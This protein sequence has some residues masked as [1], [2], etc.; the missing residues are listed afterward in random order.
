[1]NIRQLVLQG[2]SAH[3]ELKRSTGQRTEAAKTACAM[4]NGDGGVIIFGVTDKGEICGQQVSSKTIEDVLFEI[5]RIDPPVFPHVEKIP[6]KEDLHLILVTIAKGEDVYTYDGRP[7]LRQGPTTIIMPREEYEQ[8]VIEKMHPYKRWEKE[9]VPSGISIS[10]LD[11]EEMLL[12]LQN[13]VALGRMTSPKKDDVRSILTGLGLIVEGRLINA[14]VVLYGKS[15][16]LEALYPQF[17]LRIARFRGINRLGD[18][19]DN[20]Q[21]WGHAFYLMRRAESFLL[22]HMQIAGRVVSGKLKREDYPA[23]APRAVREALANAICHRDYMMHGGAVS[24]AMYDDHLEIVNPGRLHFGMT[25]KKLIRPHASK[26]WNP[27]VASVFYRAGII[28]KW[29]T[30]TLN[31]LDWCKE[32]KNPSPTWLDDDD[33]VIVT[34]APRPSLVLQEQPESRPE[35]RPESLKEKILLLLKGQAL[36]T[37]ELS[38]QLKQ[39]QVSGQLKKLLRGLVKEKMIA[40][41]IPEKPGSRLQKYKLMDEQ[42]L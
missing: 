7:Y 35:S 28:E 37:T 20:R 41:T 15:G 33:S 24:F 11:E 27:I 29:G 12:T 42:L 1:M 18:F 22:D 31:I 32:N 16:S 8:R 40:H 19:L 17:S 36:S 10:D 23:Y 34:F 2:E 26:P 4:L 13:A 38:S 30:G 5:R 39:K 25:P 14:A 3:V 6:W 9:P 21:Y